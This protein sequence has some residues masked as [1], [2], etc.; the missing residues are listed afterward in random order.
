M[1]NDCASMCVNDEGQRSLQPQNQIKHVA[2]SAT[3]T[4]PLPDQ[5]YD[6][7]YQPHREEV[8][9]GGP[10]TTAEA[11]R[12]VKT[13]DNVISNNQAYTFTL[14]NGAVY[15]GQMQGTKREGRGRQKWV[16]GSEYTGDWRDDKA[17]GYGTYTHTNGSR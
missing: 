14:D 5:R 6:P 7:G 8:T 10:L 11:Q 12:I 3:Y 2:P 15:E 1:G 16:D 9:R 17:N 4:N 13:G